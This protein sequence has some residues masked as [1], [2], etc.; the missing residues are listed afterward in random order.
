MEAKVL[1]LEK[2]LRRARRG[3]AQELAS[4]AAMRVKEQSPLQ[5]TQV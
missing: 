5:H 4:A 1:G 2:E 3:V